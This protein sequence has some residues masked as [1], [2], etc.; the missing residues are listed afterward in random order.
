MWRS[1]AM[2]IVISG[3]IRRW[4]VKAL[5]YQDGNRHS[6]AKAQSLAFPIVGL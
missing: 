1:E 6:V 3:L 5:A 4:I 2:E